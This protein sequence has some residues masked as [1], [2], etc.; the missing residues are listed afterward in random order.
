[1]KMR[2][3]LLAAT[4][5]AASVMPAVAVEVRDIIEFGE[6]IPACLD[7]NDTYRIKLIE[8]A[9]RRHALADQYISTRR[10]KVGNNTSIP[11]CYWIHAGEARYVADKR[12]TNESGFMAGAYFCMGW[13]IGDT[14]NEDKT[15]SCLW[16]YMLDRPTK[17]G[18][19]VPMRTYDD[20]RPK[21]PETI[22]PHNPPFGRWNVDGAGGTDP[23]MIDEER[24]RMDSCLNSPR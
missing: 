7:I 5:L 11:A 12:S 3:F 13:L 18:Q 22:D 24:K 15:K 4:A 14:D 19:L 17:N 10:I 9:R 1:M 21:P 8:G 20:C 2:K 6:P 23:R 16:V